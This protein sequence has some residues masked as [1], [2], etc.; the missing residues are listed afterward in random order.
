MECA[1]YSRS[2]RLSSKREPGHQRA[3]LQEETES[4][5]P[6]Y[7]PN[8]ISTSREYDPNNPRKENRN[9]I[10]PLTERESQLQSIIQDSIL[11]YPHKKSPHNLQLRRNIRELAIIKLSLPE[12]GVHI[13]E[14]VVHPSFLLDV[15]KVNETT[16]VGITV[17]SGENGATAQSQRVLL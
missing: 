15:V 5:L 12:D 7:W 4:R 3:T 11:S 13:I 14:A 10:I 1:Y 8:T 16:R 17:H 6:S 9:I 2:I